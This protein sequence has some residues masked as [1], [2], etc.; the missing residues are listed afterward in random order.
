MIQ[1]QDSD[2]FDHFF[3]DLSKPIPGG[4]DALIS[5]RK[6]KWRKDY[7]NSENRMFSRYKQ[8]IAC[9]NEEKK[10]KPDSQFLEEMDVLYQ[11]A[12]K[13]PSISRFEVVMVRRR[14]RRLAEDKA[15]REVGEAI[16]EDGPIIL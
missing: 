12:A 2:Y 16:P 15:L 13:A 1:I 6:T 11:T 5:E 14:K 8:I 3:I 9:M 10:D 4:V 7:E